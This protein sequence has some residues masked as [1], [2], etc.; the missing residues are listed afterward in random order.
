MNSI[1][2]RVA[3]TLERGV[4]ID[5]ST[6][7]CKR[8]LRRH[9]NLKTSVVVLYVDIDGSTNMTLSMPSGTLATILQLFSQEMSLVVA[10]YGGYVL[11][12]VGDAVIALFPAEHDKK[13]AC[14]SALECGRTMLEVVDRCI[15]PVFRQRGYAELRVKISMDFG[16][17]LVLLYGK[18]LENS[19]IDIIGSSISMAAKM[20]AIVP[21]GRI[22]MGQSV[23]DNLPEEISKTFVQFDVDES[24][25]S[26]VDQ[27]K[28]RYRLYITIPDSTRER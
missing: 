12:Y 8:Y 15:N 2:A 13:Q 18:S 1:Q 28:K 27:N 4:Q 17:V 7:L 19:H 10:N 20:L 26:Y 11:K 22:I 23:R 14:Q 5:L 21:T 3:Q 9:A 6:A 24:M 25:W 16:E